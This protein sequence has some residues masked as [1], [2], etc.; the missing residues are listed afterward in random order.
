MVKGKKKKVG[1][2]KLG[3]VYVGRPKVLEGSYSDVFKNVAIEV[4]SFSFFTDYG[5]EFC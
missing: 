4:I 3:K 1:N 5:I 2:E